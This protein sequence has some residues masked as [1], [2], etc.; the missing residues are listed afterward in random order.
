MNEDEQDAYEIA[1]IALAAR[2]KAA[3]A[4]ATVPEQ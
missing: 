3:K 4:K 2:M 1:E